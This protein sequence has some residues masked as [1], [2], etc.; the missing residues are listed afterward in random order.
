MG[1]T[2]GGMGLPRS[3]TAQHLSQFPSS[4]SRSYS[5]PD[6][7]S[8]MYSGMGGLGGRKNTSPSSME[9][10]RKYHHHI[11][12]SASSPR[13][14]MPPSRRSSSFGNGMGGMG[15]IGPLRHSSSTSGGS[16][17]VQSMA[18]STSNLSEFFSTLQGLVQ[19]S[20][21]IPELNIN[22]SKPKVVRGES[23]F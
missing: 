19:R 8:D 15:P 7:N 20:Q 18:D 6:H 10:A 9:P 2:N 22:I 14:F 13:G 1:S 4:M 23:S 16:E 12:H 5:N 17:R 11:P 21:E 3:S